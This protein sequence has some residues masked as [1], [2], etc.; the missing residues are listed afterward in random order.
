MS[1]SDTFIRVA[2]H[3]CL[4][5]SLLPKRFGWGVHY[6]TEGKISL[7]GKESPEYVYFISQG[8]DVVK[9]VLHQY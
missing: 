4:R 2:D 9:L 7:Y 6:N 8:E 3:P 5:A 1:Y